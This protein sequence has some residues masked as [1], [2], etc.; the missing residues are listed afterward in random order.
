LIVHIKVALIGKFC[1]V[2]TSQVNASEDHNCVNSLINSWSQTWSQFFVHTSSF[3]NLYLKGCQFYSIFFLERESWSQP[4][5]VFFIAPQLDHTPKYSIR[6]FFGGWGYVKEGLTRSCFHASILEFQSYS[7]HINHFDI[8]SKQICYEESQVIPIE[9]FSKVT[10]TFC[11][12][13]GEN[14]KWHFFGQ[15]VQTSKVSSSIW[16]FFTISFFRF[17]IAFC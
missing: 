14:M 13:F 12:A 11:F 7:R 6:V 16:M 5:H 4:Y 2:D 9:R 3:S 8:D 1:F 17:I 10:K 15:E